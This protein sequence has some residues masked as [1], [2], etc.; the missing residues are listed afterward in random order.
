MVAVVVEAALVVEAEQALEVT[1]VVV[2]LEATVVAWEGKVAMGALTV[3][4]SHGTCSRTAKFANR[5]SGFASKHTCW[6]LG[7]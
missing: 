4:Q 3:D 5:R 6:G 2:V 7:C 1:W